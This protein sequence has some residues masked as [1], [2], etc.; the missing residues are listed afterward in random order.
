MI[1]MDA[2]EQ[3]NSVSEQLIGAK[4]KRTPIPESGTLQ[5]NGGNGTQINYLAK[6]RTEKLKIIEGDSETFGDVLGMIDD[7]EG[8]YILFV[9]TSDHLEVNGQCDLRHTD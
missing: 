8:T 1:P 4:R 7:Y 3:S 6:A 2:M 5:L 9:V